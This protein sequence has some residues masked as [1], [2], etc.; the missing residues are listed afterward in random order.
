MLGAIIGDSIGSRF[1]FGN[2]PRKGFELFT[3]ECSF[4]DDTVCTI[5]VADAVLN[6]RSYKESLLEWCARYPEPMGG[7]GSRFE[8]WLRSP[9]SAPANSFGN[10]SAMRVSS[11]GWLFNGFHAVLDEARRSAEVSHNHPEG[12]KGAQCIAASIY[13]LRT[14]RVSKDELE[15]AVG[16]RFGYDIPPLRNVYKIGSE[17]HFD[18]TCQETVPMALRCFLHSENFEDAVRLAVL[19]DG[20]T[21]TKAA[22]TGSVAEAHYNVPEKLIEQACDRL[23]VEMLSVLERFYNKME[24]G[25]KL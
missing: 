25:I 12:I 16:R 14:C 24:V 9:D 1:E 2:A 23:P 19:A 6:E 22:I 5:A 13:W 3:N 17:G 20:D 10:G 15:E 18:A 21:D 11:I 8:S 7:Y 4:T